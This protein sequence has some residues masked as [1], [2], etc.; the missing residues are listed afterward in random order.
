MLAFV[1]LNIQN[2]SFAFGALISFLAGQIIPLWMFPDSLRRI[3]LLLP[4]RSIFDVPMSI[5][6]GHLN[7]LQLQQAVIQQ[8]IWVVVLLV[9]GQFCWRL[10]QRYVV[11]QGG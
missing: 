1:T 8:V 2:V 9:L 7:G 3:V 6:I 4:F 5:Y 11:S 10:V